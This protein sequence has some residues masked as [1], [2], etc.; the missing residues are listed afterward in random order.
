MHFSAPD[1]NM[2][3]WFKQLAVLEWQ[4]QCSLIHRALESRQNSS[5]PATRS[6]KFGQMNPKDSSGHLITLDVISLFSF[7]FLFCVFFFFFSIVPGLKDT[8]FWTC[9]GTVPQ[10]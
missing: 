7:F 3:L 9:G 4:S 6:C 5:K 8:L 10:L 2:V 1:G